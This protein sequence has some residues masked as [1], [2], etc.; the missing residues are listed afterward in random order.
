MYLL[1]IQLNT[2]ILKV[3]LDESMWNHISAYEKKKKNSHLLNY[4]DLTVSA[5]I[6]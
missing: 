2:F 6:I 4:E 3:I 1:F 5:S